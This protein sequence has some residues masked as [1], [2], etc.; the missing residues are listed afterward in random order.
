MKEVRLLKLQ[1]QNFK[2][3]KWLDIDAP[4]G[5]NLS[6]YGENGT[7]KTTI[8]DAFFWL[9]FGKDSFG[10]SDFEIKTLDADGRVINFLD[11]S[12][13]A[14]LKIED[15]AVSLQKTLREKWVK[16]RGSM[17]REFAGHETEYFIN[18]IP[19][20]KTEYT[21]FIKGIADEDVFRLLTNPMYFNNTLDKKKRREMLFTMFGNV[22]DTDVLAENHAVLGDLA[23]E[24]GKY[25]LDE[26]RT[27]TGANKRRIDKDLQS[28][29]NRI[30][31]INRFIVDTGENNI[32]SLRSELQAI[33]NS[34]KVKSDELSNQ[35]IDREIETKQRETSD[36]ISILI[37]DCQANKYKL[38]S[39]HAELIH[40][41]QSI[42]HSINEKSTAIKSVNLTL[43][44]NASAIE[45]YKTKL[46][47]L[48]TEWEEVF[49][50]KYSGGNKCLTCGQQLPDERIAEMINNFNEEKARKL[51]SINEEA[52]GIKTAIQV[53]NAKNIEIENKQSVLTAEIDT[54][55]DELGKV[56]IEA[57]L[58]EYAISEIED[59]TKTEIAAINAGFEAWKIG[60]L[61]GETE[62]TGRKTLEEEI[63]ALRA[64]KGVISKK[65][66]DIEQ[67]EIFKAR[68]KELE[69]E[70]KKLSAEYERLEK[71]DYLISEFTK[72]KSSMLEDKINSKFKYA[73]FKL[74]EQQINGGV[75]ETCEVTYNGVPYSVLNNAMKMN[76]G[77]D[78]INAFSKH[79]DMSAVIFLD[80]AESVTK[81]FDTDSQQIRLYVSETDKQLRI[82]NKN[83]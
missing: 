62:N 13:M 52:D 56:I 5:E 4:N 20:S 43:S 3:L 69:S 46:S 17:D 11:H 44:T 36:K 38:K 48:R 83:I 58:K 74:F 14:E 49:N 77:L 82:E 57:G 24:L 15:K 55:T 81:I 59:K 8:A 53:I 31:E 50:S 34:I 6:I 10:R 28:I 51:K 2:G 30:D 76:I 78:I 29:P 47:S 1:A 60:Y 40:K 75:A 22:S 67:S 71:L 39:E 23:D 18:G 35:N 63:K 19:K 16:Q 45:K 37:S 70:A 54:L 80:N 26:L 32:D 72:K 12:V 41:R 9:L 21:A 61:S 25:T 66:T 68:I 42:E 73:R 79:Y 65:I 64:S 33:D 7:G 27:A